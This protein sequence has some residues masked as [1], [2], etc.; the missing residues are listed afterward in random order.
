MDPDAR[1]DPD[2][3]RGPGFVMWMYCGT[4]IP[5]VEDHK[6]EKRCGDHE[7]LGYGEPRSEEDESKLVVETQAPESGMGALDAQGLWAQGRKSIEWIT[8]DGRTDGSPG[9]DGR[10]PMASR[11]RGSRTYHDII[12][13]RTSRRDERDTVD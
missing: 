10:R 8:M 3:W 13:G 6:V 4:I 1:L 2:L 7:R 5:R 9:L 12:T 11:C